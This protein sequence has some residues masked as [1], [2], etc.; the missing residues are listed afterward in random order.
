MIEGQTISTCGAKT[1]TT[2][3][4]TNDLAPVLWEPGDREGHGDDGDDGQ[5]GAA[6]HPVH[7]GQHP[8]PDPGE[9]ESQISTFLYLVM[10]TRE[11]IG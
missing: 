5:G 8:H 1:K 7:T 4:E 10:W 2:C 6:H 9:R 3:N 11:A